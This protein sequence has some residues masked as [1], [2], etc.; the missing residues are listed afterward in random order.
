MFEKLRQLD[1][2]DVLGQVSDVES[3]QCV[4]SS[5]EHSVLVLERS[6]TG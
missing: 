5:D 3:A 2:G 6:A 4:L 1:V